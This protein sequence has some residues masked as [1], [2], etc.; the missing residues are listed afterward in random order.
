MVDGVGKQAEL[1]NMTLNSRPFWDLLI[2]FV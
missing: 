2:A 1:P